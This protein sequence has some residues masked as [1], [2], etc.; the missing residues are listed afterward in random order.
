VN[1]AIP[2]AVQIGEGTKETP[3]GKRTLHWSLMSE[4]ECLVSLVSGYET[5]RVEGTFK[6]DDESINRIAPILA[7]ED[8]V[9]M[10]I[11]E[12]GSRIA[13]DMPITMGRKFHQGMKK[14]I[15]KYMVIQ[16]S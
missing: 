13:P 3:D 9:Y 14:Y 12:I 5:L 6:E 4:A 15:R 1:Y 10:I 2:K 16:R 8:A 11:Y 7:S